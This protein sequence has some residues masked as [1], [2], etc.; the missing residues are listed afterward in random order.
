MGRIFIDVKKKLKVSSTMNF[1]NLRIPSRALF[2]SDRGR[3]AFHLDVGISNI[4]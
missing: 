1:G 3:V 2:R 4:R